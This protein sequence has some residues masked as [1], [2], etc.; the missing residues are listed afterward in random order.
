VLI[1]DSSP[2]EIERGFAELGHNRPDALLLGPE[3]ALGRNAR[4]ITG[5][6]Q[7]SRLPAIYPY[8]VYAE[9]GGLI[10]YTFDPAD[11]D[12]QLAVDVHLP[13]PS[14]DSPPSPRLP[15]TKEVSTQK[16]WT[17]EVIHRASDPPWQCWR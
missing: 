12:R 11:L 3:P 10:T 9:H 15:V 17:G 1:R 8:P 16:R 6:A 5:L 13:V 4:L 14:C 2:P 7:Q